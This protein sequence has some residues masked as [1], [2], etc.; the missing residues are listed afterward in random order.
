MRPIRSCAKAIIVRD[1]RILTVKYSDEG[2]EYYALPGGGQLHGE[3]LPA[4]LLRECRE[5]LGVT[6][7]SLGLRFIREYIGKEGESRWRDADVHR[8]E[9]LYECALE[10]GQEPQMGRHG[11]H[12]QVD[13]AWLPIESISQYRFYP[14]ALVSYLGS[15]FPDRIEYWGSVD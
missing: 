7:V 15:P 5:E 13:I 10:P 12:S 11:D 4:T 2:G 1:E 9:F 3:T 6:V 8:V 14:R